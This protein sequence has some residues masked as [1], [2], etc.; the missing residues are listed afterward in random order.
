[1]V[2]ACE[3]ALMH[4]Y[5]CVPTRGVWGHAPQENFEILS[6]CFWRNL[7]QDCCLIPVTK[8][9]SISGFLGGEFQGP[10]PSVWNPDSYS[11]NSR[12]GW[13]V[14][15]IH[16]NHDVAVPMWKNGNIISFYLVKSP[17][18]VGTKLRDRE[19]SCIVN[20]SGDMRWPASSSWKFGWGVSKLRMNNSC[21]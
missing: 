9:Y 7:G 11:I 18:A 1:M 2:V 8:P 16:V 20:T 21:H 13:F 12:Y 5:A 6:D 10:P 15:Y 4:T 14:L 3:S 17:V 19:I